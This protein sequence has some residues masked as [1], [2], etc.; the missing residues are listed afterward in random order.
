MDAS[1]R[2]WIKL[3]VADTEVVGGAVSS[4]AAA[5]DKIWPY[6]GERG[7]LI[8]SSNSVEACSMLL[9]FRLNT[10]LMRQEGSNTSLMTRWM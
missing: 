3:I 9:R 2:L 4:A 5:L 1:G 10:M 6:A 8:F 7:L